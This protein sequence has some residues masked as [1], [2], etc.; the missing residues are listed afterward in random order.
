MQA[1]RA[2]LPERQLDKLP[3]LLSAVADVWAENSQRAS[4]NPVRA[5]D[6]RQALSELTLFLSHTHGD[7]IAIDDLAV[8]QAQGSW[9]LA[10]LRAARNLLRRNL[11]RSEDEDV[12]DLAR[13]PDEARRKERQMWRNNGIEVRSFATRASP[14]VPTRLR[15]NNDKIPTF[16]AWWG[17]ICKPAELSHTDFTYRLAYGACCAGPLA[18]ALRAVATG[19]EP[20]RGGVGIPHFG[21]PPEK[22]SAWENDAIVNS[23][24]MLW[25]N[26][27]DTRIVQGDH[28]DIIGHYQRQADPLYA[29]S[30]TSRGKA[31]A[32]LRRRGRKYGAYDFFRSGSG[33]VEPTFV[34]VWENVFSF[35]MS[36][37]TVIS[38]RT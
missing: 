38:A 34:A 12:T 27:P 21:G 16:R 23:A 2:A 37:Q 13:T 36:A 11:K 10:P 5:A 25:P 22:L 26:G 17:L 8:R 20:D 1:I 24:S 9:L 6:G 35:C 29:T 19:S 14:G 3:D 28:G 32:R 15:N 4:S 7:F 30:G 18:Q 31:L 33:F